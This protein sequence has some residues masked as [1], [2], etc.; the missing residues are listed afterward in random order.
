MSTLSFFFY[1]IINSHV[2]LLLPDKVRNLPIHSWVFCQ[3]NGKKFLG[4]LLGL[5]ERE[6]RWIV[7]QDFQRNSCIIVTCFFDLFLWR[8]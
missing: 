3:K 2:L 5:D 8:P 7:K 6:C 4:N 1:L